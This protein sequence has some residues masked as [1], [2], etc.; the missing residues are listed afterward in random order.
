MTSSQKSTSVSNTESIA[1]RVNFDTIDQQ[2]ATLRALLKLPV[3]ER[4]A[5]LAEQAAAIAHLFV[6]GSEEMEWA[7]KYVEDENWDLE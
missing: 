6:S 7:E 1:H 2:I 3:K 4:S 5:I